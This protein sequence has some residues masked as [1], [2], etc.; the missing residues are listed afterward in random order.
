MIINKLILS[1]LVVISYAKANAWQVDSGD[2][3]LWAS[4]IK[5]I[6]S[7]TQQIHLF[8]DRNNQS[9]NPMDYIQNFAGDVQ[10]K[11]FTEMKTSYTC[12]N[13][14]KV[15]FLSSVLS[16]SP[17]MARKFEEGFLRIESLN[18]LGKL[19][20]DK[21]FKVFMS[22]EF[23]QKTIQGLKKI[24]SDENKNIVCQETSIFS[25][26]KS[27]YCFTQHIWKNDSKYVIHSFNETNA[28]GIDAAVYFREVITVFE[29]LPSQDIVVY[30]LAYGRGPD[31]S[32]KSI[33]KGVIKSQQESLITELIRSA[34][35]L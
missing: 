35:S 23:Q 8:W 24:T 30:N 18:C 14:I 22:N 25:I 17:V 28:P 6:S 2:Y 32:F 13:E 1:L 26:G 29:Q 33:V 31:L 7:V 9:D 27:S 3:N 20:L 10:K 5:P 21:V 11:I 19:N 15:D 16:N 4:Q 12:G 34:Q